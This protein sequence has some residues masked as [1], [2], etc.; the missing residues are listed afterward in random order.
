MHALLFQVSRLQR[1]PD[2][3]VAPLR[4]QDITFVGAG[5]VSGDLK[6][7]SRDFDCERLV[8]KTNFANLCDIMTI[9][10]LLVSDK[11]IDG[12]TNGPS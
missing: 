3:L 2:R 9:Y 4:D 11:I 8:S 7:I 12:C 5:G 6:K 10:C 1:L